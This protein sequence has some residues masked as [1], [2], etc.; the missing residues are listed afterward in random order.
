MVTT[1]LIPVM[2]RA[3][4][5][6]VRWSTMLAFTLA[7]VLRVHAATFTVTVGGDGSFQPPS[8]K[9]FD[10]DTV[11]WKLANPASDAIVRLRAQ[12]APL[13]QSRTNAAADAACNDYRV[14]DAADPNE[15]TGPMPRAASGIFTISP[16]GPGFQ[17]YSGALCTTKCSNKIAEV[18]NNIGVK[19][20][21]GADASLSYATMDA[22]WSDPV[23]SGV[24]IRLRWN[25]VHK[26]LGRFD[27]TVLDREISKAVAQGK[28]YSIGIKAGR[29]GT[30]EWIETEVKPPVRRFRFVDHGGTDGEDAATSNGDRCGKEMFLGSP[31][32][33]AFRTQYFAML[34][35]L[36]ARIRAKSAWYRALA[37]VKPSG[38]NLFSHE[39]RAPK[40]CD[41]GC[42]CNPGV[43]AKQAGYKPSELQTFYR[44]QLALFKRE[45]PG[46]DMAYA[47]IQAGFPLVG[48]FG[49]FEGQSPPP[50][51]IGKNSKPCAVLSKG[52]LPWGTQQTEC[53]LEESTRDHPGNFVVQHNGLGPACGDRDGNGKDDCLP[54]NLVVQ[55]GK[56]GRIIGF[57]TNNATKVGNNSQLD[58]ALQNGYCNSDATFV[59]IYEERAWEARN[60]GGALD[61]APSQLCDLSNMKARTLA[62]WSNQLLARRNLRA[63]ALALP[64]FRSGEHRHVFK[65]TVATGQ[66]TFRYSHGSRCTPT[67]AGKPATITIAPPFATNSATLR[68]TATSGLEDIPPAGKNLTSRQS[69]LT[70]DANIALRGLTLREAPGRA[71]QLS[72]WYANLRGQP[73]RSVTLQNTA[74]V[75]SATTCS[76]GE[77]DKTVLFESESQYVHGLRV[78]VGG[79]F[80]VRG[81]EI[82]S[83]KV[84]DN[85]NVITAGQTSQ[86]MTLNGCRTW[87]QIVACGPQKIAVGVTTFFDASRGYVGVGL[88]CKGVAS[89]D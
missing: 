41:A 10:G 11:L 26:G 32:D 20:L 79:N 19:C 57:Q 54:Q 24:F 5:A 65:R 53:V 85:A 13:L 70:P 9:V 23:I 36:A 33:A 68:S 40:N 52:Q 31:A 49:E 61:T 12:T 86:R 21:C 2:F 15:F 25:E 17:E 35:A 28:L 58:G 62:A 69:T 81:I 4:C 45:F 87:S 22:T 16:D 71:C 42:L 74:T 14:Y 84:D 67:G 66:Q 7:C 82:F 34:T 30:P 73:A 80:D 51:Q 39:N 64:E 78:C 8:Q 44:E 89:L 55:A 60:R 29:E 47:L 27:W 46:K 43:W 3:T 75:P 48:E 6:T 38:V 50:L 1:P 63:R 18:R 77:P 59:E 56:D 83:A 76:G 37:Y 88:Q 72:L